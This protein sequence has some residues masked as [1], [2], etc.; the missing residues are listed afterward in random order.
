MKFA[1]SAKEIII[2]ILKHQGMVKISVN[3]KG[4]GIRK[5]MLPDLFDRYYRVYSSGSQCSCLGPGLYICF[6]LDMVKDKSVL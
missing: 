5:D 6:T 2:D 4:P 1:P 3:D